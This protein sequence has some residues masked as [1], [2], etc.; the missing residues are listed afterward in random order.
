L[1]GKEILPFFETIE[2]LPSLAA[3]RRAFSA[4]ILIALTDYERRLLVVV[5]DIAI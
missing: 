4:L 5:T 2:F 1:I 3:Q